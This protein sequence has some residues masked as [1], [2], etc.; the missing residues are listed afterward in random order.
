MKKVDIGYLSWDENKI[1]L[2][3]AVPF[4]INVSFCRGR[5]RSAKSWHHFIR[6]FFYVRVW[7]ASL[8]FYGHPTGYRIIKNYICTNNPVDVV[9][10]VRIPFCY[11]IIW[12]RRLW[13]RVYILKFKFYRLF[14]LKYKVKWMTTLSKHKA[15]CRKCE[16][17][18]EK[19]SDLCIFMGPGKDIP[20]GKYHYKC[21]AKLYE[22]RERKKHDK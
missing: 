3:H 9:L 22:V 11:P 16:E 14:R 19:V 2:R 10:L 6:M 20:H 8:Y 21:L 7:G 17:S 1:I 12:I 5:Y 13:W 4:P 18:I 15:I